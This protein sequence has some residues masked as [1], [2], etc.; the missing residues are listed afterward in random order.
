ME[1]W[2]KVHLPITNTAGA[3]KLFET[4]QIP[5]RSY[6]SWKDHTEDIIIR[7]FRALLKNYENEEIKQPP[8]HRIYELISFNH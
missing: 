6:L 3:T 5:S 8:Q 2:V 1:C 7:H 4:A